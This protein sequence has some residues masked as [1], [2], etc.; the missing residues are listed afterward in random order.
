MQ[1]LDLAT[2]VELAA[3]EERLGAAQK[4]FTYH[5]C[6]FH[7]VTGKGEALRAASATTYSARLITWHGVPYVCLFD[8]SSVL[9]F[10]P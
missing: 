4:L 3:L 10:E 9:E 7:L 1:V 2:A 6:I 5:K 8:G